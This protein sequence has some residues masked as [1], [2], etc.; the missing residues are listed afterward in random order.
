MAVAEIDREPVRLSPPGYTQDGQSYKQ[1]TVK[2]KPS[3][4][5]YSSFYDLCS[6]DKVHPVEAVKG[7]C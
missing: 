6:L 1:A 4:W 7:A 5:H 2:Y 3:D